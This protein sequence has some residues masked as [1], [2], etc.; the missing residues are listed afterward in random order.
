MKNKFV[1]VIF[2]ILVNLN[3][4][5]LVAAED[6]IFE[7]SALE[8]S[9]NGNIFKGKSRGKIIADSQIELLSDNFEYFKKTNQLK[10]NI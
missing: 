8:I 7:I 5:K 4:A 1:I 6:F 9:D 3:L 10:H 2:L